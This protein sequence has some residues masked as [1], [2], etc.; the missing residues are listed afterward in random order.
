MSQKGSLKWNKDREESWV[1]QKEQLNTG[2]L[3]DYLKDLFIW[4]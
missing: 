3:K 1:Q 2:D 4:S